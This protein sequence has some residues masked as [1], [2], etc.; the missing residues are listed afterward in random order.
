MT[1]K[2][3]AVDQA[4]AVQHGLTAEEYGRVVEALGRTPSYTELL[5]HLYS[6]VRAGH[7]AVKTDTV[8]QVLGRQPIPFTQ[9]VKDHRA[10]WA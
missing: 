5:S 4:L 1:V 2:E 8:L 9:F 10:V 3:P 7:T 6:V